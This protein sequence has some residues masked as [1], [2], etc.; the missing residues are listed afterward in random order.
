MDWRYLLYLAGKYVIERTDTLIEEELHL[1]V[2]LE[3][4]AEQNGQYIL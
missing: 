3:N 1:D 2:N 4:V